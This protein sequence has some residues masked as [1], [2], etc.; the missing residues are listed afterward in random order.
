[1]VNVVGANQRDNVVG[2]GLCGCSREL[3]A[4]WHKAPTLDHPS[5]LGYG[6]CLDGDVMDYDSVGR[7]GRALVEE[8]R[9][10]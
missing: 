7:M 10:G 9:N 8:I 4:A 1:L 2:Y 6:Y 5:C 3:D